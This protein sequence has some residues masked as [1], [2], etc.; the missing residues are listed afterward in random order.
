M[1]LTPNT[2]SVIEG[3]NMVIKKIM[4]SFFCLLTAILR[5][6]SIL[7]YRKEGTVPHIKSSYYIYLKG[8]EV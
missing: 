5:L 3:R 7:I 8:K 4:I 2:L 1:D 6:S